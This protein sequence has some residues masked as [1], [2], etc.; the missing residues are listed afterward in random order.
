MYPP[1]A[2]AFAT[3]VLLSAPSVVGAQDTRGSR[4]TLAVMYFNNNAL[5]DRDV[6][7]ALSKGIADILITDLLRNPSL[8]V[9]DRDRLQDVLEEQDLSQ[10]GRVDEETAV[11]VGR[12]LGAGHIVVGGFFVDRSGNVRLDARAVEVETSRIAFATSVPGKQEALLDAILT[13]GRRLSSGLRLGS[14]REPPATDNTRATGRW[15]ALLA[16]ARA[17][18]ADDRGNLRGAVQ[19]YEEFLGTTPPTFAVEQRRR[20]TERLRVLKGAGSG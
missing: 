14:A 1:L 16:Y 8:R 20:A 6:Y 11:R 5:V 17:L 13:L 19:H 3:L 12:L 7:D 4:A 10:T 2:A 18:D 15:K 9:I